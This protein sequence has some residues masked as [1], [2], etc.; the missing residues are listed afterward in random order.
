MKIS[1]IH[2]VNKPINVDQLVIF[3]FETFS[4][5]EESRISFLKILLFD[6]FDVVLCLV[7]VCFFSLFR[8][9]SSTGRGS[10]SSVA[11]S[12]SSDLAAQYVQVEVASPD[13]Q[14]FIV[15]TE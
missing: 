12:P 2:W 11:M 6:I 13:D 5:V 10:S 9:G 7:M 15:Y 8:S 3:V 4:Q 1:R 14:Q